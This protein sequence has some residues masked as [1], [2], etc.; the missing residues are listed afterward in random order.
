MPNRLRNL[1]LPWF[2]FT[3]TVALALGLAVA[4][5]CGPWL[6]DAVDWPAAVQPVAA[7]LAAD[8]LVRRT[9]VVSAA[10]LAVTAFVFFR[11][12]RR[13]RSKPLNIPGA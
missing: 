4:V 5:G 11:P 8:A 2:C 1:W 6:A 12:R 7:L 9:A 10:G 13:P 3:L